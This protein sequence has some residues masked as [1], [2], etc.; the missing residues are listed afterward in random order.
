M[1]LKTSGTLAFTVLAALAL[2]GCV[3]TPAPAPVAQPPVVVQTPAPAQAP[4]VVVTPR[5]Y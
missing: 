5:A 1:T 3:S 2:A 4:S